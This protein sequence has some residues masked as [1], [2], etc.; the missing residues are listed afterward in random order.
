MYLVVSDYAVIV[1]L[2]RQAQEDGEKPIYY[3]MSKALVDAKT[4]YSQVEQTTLALR[5]AA[6]KL[7]PY[8]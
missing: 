6:K 3:N 5:V 8:F 1:I 4:H 2:F 7:Y